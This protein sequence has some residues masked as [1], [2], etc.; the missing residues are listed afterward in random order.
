MNF[1]A[2]SQNTRYGVDERERVPAGLPSSFQK[3]NSLRV[4]GLGGEDE[5]KKGNYLRNDIVF[6]VSQDVVESIISN[7]RLLY[8]VCP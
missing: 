7:P 4:K 1:T 2:G 3:V 8:Y 6:K 5:Y